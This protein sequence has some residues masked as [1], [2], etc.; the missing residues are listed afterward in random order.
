M[1]I[2][3]FSILNYL[4]STDAHKLVMITNPAN[5][6][7]FDGGETI[8]ITADACDVDGS[9]IKVEFFDGV[10]KIGEDL[11]EPYSFGWMG[12][13]VGHTETA[14]ITPITLGL[15]L[16]HRRASTEKRSHQCRIS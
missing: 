1:R 2:G 16:T 8:T 12:A 15:R 3:S 13:S 10:S 11:T 5:G 7:N 14:V 4:S 6:Y 9:I